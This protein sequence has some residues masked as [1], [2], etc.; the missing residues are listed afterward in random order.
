MKFMH[1]INI[2]IDGEPDRVTAQEKGE[3]VESYYKNGVLRHRVKHYE[4]PQVTAAKN[5]LAYSIKRYRPEKPI[6]GP[7]AVHIA[8]YFPTDKKKDYYQPKLT[9][10]DVDNMAKGCLDVMTQMRFWNDDNQVCKL[11]LMKFWAPREEAGTEITIYYD[12]IEE[13]DENE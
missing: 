12:P 9:K 7:I 4:K 5:K 3:T 11:T 1:S 2:D 6:S 8:W 13:D 10:P